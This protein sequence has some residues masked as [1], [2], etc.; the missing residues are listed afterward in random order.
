MK[1]VWFWPNVIAALSTAGLL[2]GLIYEG[3]GDVF[4]W[5]TLG[6]PVAAAAWYG[7]YRRPPA[8]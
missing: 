1:K 6:I 5:V 2:V 7:W 3:L 4:A 8:G